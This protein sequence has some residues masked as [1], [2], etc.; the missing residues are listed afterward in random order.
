MKKLVSIVLMVS[1]LAGMLGMLAGCGGPQGTV[2]EGATVV[3]LY[4]QNF[5]QWNNEYLQKRVEEFNQILDDGIQLEVKFFTDSAY[6]DALMV[7]RENGTGLDLYMISYGNLWSEV[8]NGRCVPL[9]DLL[10]QECFDDLTDAGKN[11]VTYDDKY[12]AYPTLIEAS[13]LLYYR[14]ENEQL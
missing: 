11:L 7:A 8:E 14:K 10:E 5:E 3:T 1:M 9:N 13:A 4:A 6:N 12:Y 2:E